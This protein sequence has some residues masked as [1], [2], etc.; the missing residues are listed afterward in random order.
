MTQLEINIFPDG[1]TPGTVTELC[2]EE[3]C[4]KTQFLLHLLVG[5]IL[6][7]SQNGVEIGGLETGVLLIDTECQFST[8]RLMGILE[9]RIRH[10]PSRSDAD[11]ET[12]ISEE[13]LDSVIRDSLKRLH[14][15]R[16]HSSDNLLLTLHSVESL[17]SA[18]SNI[19]LLLLD[20]MSAFYWIDRSNI[21]DSN[22]MREAAFAKK[23]SA[24]SH[25]VRTYKLAA[26]VTTTALFE[27]RRT[28]QGGF[29]GDDGSFG[30]AAPSS[31]SRESHE[32]SDYLGRS[33][34]RLVSQRLVFAKQMRQLGQNSK[35]SGATFSVSLHSP[36]MASVVKQFTLEDH[37][38]HF[39]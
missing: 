15:V 6:P 1:P 38:V 39:V 16:C 30:R 25:L 36:S 8:V 14:L 4:G 29:G 9:S 22:A 31:E 20:S 18:Q 26:F 11:G 24:L 13:N 35:Q 17:L 5:A 19:G 34:Q 32:Y 21:P 23:T 33:W 3:G 27:K 28:Q 12:S 10:A 7:R 37:G 2:G